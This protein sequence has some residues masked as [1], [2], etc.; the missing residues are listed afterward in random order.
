MIF[1]RLLL[2]VRWQAA[3]VAQEAR[4]GRLTSY[5]GIMSYVRSG[6]ASSSKLYTVLFK[7]GEDK[8]PRPP[9]PP[10]SSSQD[11]IIMKWINQGALNN[12]CDAC[13]TSNVTFAASVMPIIGINCTGCHSGASPSGSTLLTN[14]A[15][16]LAQVNNGKLI[17]SV[18]YASGFNGMPVTTK[19]SDCDINTLKIWVRN[20][21]PNN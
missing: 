3:T 12:Q 21:A 19:L 4:R 13:D 11:S 10:L 14:Y 15:D 2:I 7:S 16:I 1:C 18:T 5:S 6:S 9:V 20:G 17:S 8:M